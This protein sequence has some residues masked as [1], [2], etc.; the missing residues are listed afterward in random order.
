MC[1]RRKRIQESPALQ[2]PL[3]L[4]EMQLPRCSSRIPNLAMNRLW[5]KS[6]PIH[7][8]NAAAY[9]ICSGLVTPNIDISKNLPR[10]ILRAV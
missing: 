1:A 10:S 4:L 5:G 7:L 3:L 2:K 6:L 8:Q 9:Y